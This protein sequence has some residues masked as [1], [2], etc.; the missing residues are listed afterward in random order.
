MPPGGDL[1]EAR[2]AALANTIR[3]HM[4]VGQEGHDLRQDD[5]LIAVSPLET[6]TIL[7]AIRYMI[8][9]ASQAPRR[10]RVDEYALAITCLFA[11]LTRRAA[12]MAFNALCTRHS[13]PD[14]FQNVPGYH[15]WKEYVSGP[16]GLLSLLPAIVRLP[17]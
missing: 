3:L 4:L 12:E 16:R 15:V 9:H 13:V 17:E 11:I 6:E 8:W 14:I 2:L 5:F 1:G 7:A 10:A